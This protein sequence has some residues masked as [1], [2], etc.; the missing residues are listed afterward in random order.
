[1]AALD[2]LIVQLRT[3]LI[4]AVR[5]VCLGLWYVEKAVGWLAD[6]IVG[7]TIWHALSESILTD[8]GAAMPTV[9]RDMMFGTGGGLFYLAVFLV[10]MTL[11]V[12]YLMRQ[13]QVVELPRVLGWAIFVSALFVS[14]TTGYD[15]LWMVEEARLEMMATLAGGGAG[16]NVSNLVA[17]PMSATAG[18]IDVTTFAL[19]AAFE[20]QFFPPPSSF[21]TETLT[22]WDN[23]VMGTFELT[24]TIE[25][26]ASLDTR[27]EQAAL[28]IVL[29]ILALI[30]TAMV[31]I[32]AGAYA[33]LTA[34]ALTLLLFFVLALPAGLFEVGMQILS[35]IGMRYV[36]I[37]ALS[38][39]LALFPQVVLGIAALTLTPPVTMT[40]LFTYIAILLVAVY[41]TFHVAQWCLTV[42]KESFGAIGHAINAAL[43]PMA[44]GGYGERGYAMTPTPRP[45]PLGGLITAG[46]GLAAMNYPS[47]ATGVAAAAAV[48]FVRRFGRRGEMQAAPPVDPAPTAAA[49]SEMPLAV[50]RPPRQDVFFYLDDGLTIDGSWREA[51]QLTQGPEKEAQDA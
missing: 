25:E 22:L 17:A 26:E 33:V 31:G 40:A 23:L 44:Y 32:L 4:A 30:P 5:G 47:L 8:L 15:L 45:A 1:M 21:R 7:S 35:Q 49:A 38:L 34:G 46:V 28:G 24:F 13:S 3:L 27:Q 12:P 51:E 42:A 16:G 20:A 39:L 48:P 14:S 43:V 19:P 6:Q 9:L 41:A 2:W 11:I 37:W 50:T 36:L 10:G 18:E 29:S